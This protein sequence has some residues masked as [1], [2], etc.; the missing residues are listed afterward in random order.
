M[1]K[2]NAMR[3]GIVVLWAIAV[4]ASAGENKQAPATSRDTAQQMEAP[5]LQPRNLRYQLRPGDVLG[6]NFLFTPEFNQS[7]TV[8]PDGY[9]TLRGVG[10][11]RV[12]GLTK[13]ELTET[14]QGAYAKILYEPI[15]TVELKDFEKPYFIVGG[16]VASPGKYDLRG[17]T[18][19]TQAVAIAGGFRESAKHSQVL[20]FRRV[21]D[22]WLEVKKVNVKKLLQTANL[23]EDINLRPG[24][25]LFVPKNI[26]SKIRPYLP[27]PGVGIYY[28]PND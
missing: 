22:G 10:D 1:S 3:I 23:R 9:V 26:L 4:S 18:T 6:V 15:I 28:R 7:V 17:P 12:T 14:L 20:L 24:D 11:L 21:S 13:P 2:R 25:M 19:V 8:Q 16:E 5:M 27:I